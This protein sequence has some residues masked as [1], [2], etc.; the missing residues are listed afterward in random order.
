M[1]KELKKIP[2]K[3]YIILFTLVIMTILL[4]LYVKSWVDA[5]KENKISISPLENNINKVNANELNL[6]LKETNQIIL[7][8]SYTNDK[9]IYDMEKQL[10]KKIK[11]RELSDYMIYYNVTDT[12]TSYV[13]YLK[14]E[15]NT[16]DI[17]KAP[18]FIYLKNAE[19]KEVINSDKKLIDSDDMIYLINKYEIGK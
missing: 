18:M 10:L 13:E 19:V 6:T 12:K 16:N 2:L 11:S 3:N 8:V 7:Y 17:K 14:E 9:D 4:V 15:L 5:Y 1:K